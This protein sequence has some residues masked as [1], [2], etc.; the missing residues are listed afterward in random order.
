MR[1]EKDNQLADAI[2]RNDNR[3]VLKY[4]YAKLF[5]KIKVMIAR[6]GGTSDDAQDVFQDGVVVL[7]RKIKMGDFETSGNPEGF[8]YTMCRN[9]W[10][11]KMKRDS[12]M[13]HPEK[14]PDREDENANILHHFQIKEKEEQIRSIFDKLG[15]RCAKLLK[16][17]YLQHCN[18]EEIAREMK[19]GSTD[20]VKTSKN[21]PELVS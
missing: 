5:P 19:M 7:Y 20:V 14:L 11:N 1:I 8:L 9:I 4:L 2:L 6:F 15:E 12:K 21:R 17:I 16:M 18:S 13:M 3:E 10:L